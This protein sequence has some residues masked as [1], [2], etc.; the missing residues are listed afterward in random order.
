MDGSQYNGTFHPDQKMDQMLAQ[1][2]SAR[3]PYRL[4]YRWVAT[5]ELGFREF[6]DL[7]KTYDQSRH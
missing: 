4:V 7:M 5:R 6:T 1:M 3:D 2:H